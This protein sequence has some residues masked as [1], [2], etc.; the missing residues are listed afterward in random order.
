MVY[1]NQR[2]SLFMTQHV[3]FWP[4]LTLPL[5]VWIPWIYLRNFIPTMKPYPTVPHTFS[6]FYLHFWKIFL[7]FPFILKSQA[8]SGFVCP[9]IT[10][11]C[12]ASWKRASKVPAPVLSS[13]IYCPDAIVWILSF[14]HPLNELSARLFLKFHC[15]IRW[16]L[17]F[18]LP[19]LQGVFTI[20]NHSFPIERKLP[21]AFSE[22]SSFGSS[23]A[24][25]LACSSASLEVCRGE[26]SHSQVIRTRLSMA[27]WTGPLQHLSLIQVTRLTQHTS[28]M[29]FCT[30]I[31][32][33]REVKSLDTLPRW[34]LHFMVSRQT[35]LYSSPG[36]LRLLCSRAGRC[37][38]GS[39][40]SV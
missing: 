28:N 1:Y 8:F 38:I 33:K 12:Q 40:L 18:H 11:P 13:P 25:F 17:S 19:I 34:D 3:L 31:K 24:L 5:I 6:F 27:P 10:W 35:N 9:S 39:V 29:T 30:L 32:E 21:L 22:E 23:P 14:M 37:L 26:L 2:L 4:R 36:T 16:L 20:A 7:S 15:C